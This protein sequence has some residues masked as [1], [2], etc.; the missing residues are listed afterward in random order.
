[1]KVSFD[2]DETLDNENIQKYALKLIKDG[3]DVHIV[4]SRPSFM[5]NNVDLYKIA[6]KLSIKDENIHFTDYIPKYKFF[7][8]NEDFIFHIDNDHAEIFEINFYTKTKGILFEE[9]WEENCNKLL[10]P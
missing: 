2:F 1:M 3:F 6:K 7:E 9:F 10:K 4:T 8:K 5:L